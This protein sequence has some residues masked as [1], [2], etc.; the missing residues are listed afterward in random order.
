MRA[1]RF[2]DTQYTAY[3]IYERGPRIV[4]CCFFLILIIELVQMTAKITPASHL[5]LQ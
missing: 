3:E 4:L 2:D 1:G 5:D